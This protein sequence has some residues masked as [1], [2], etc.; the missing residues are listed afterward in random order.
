VKSVFFKQNRKHSPLLVVVVDQEKGH[1]AQ[2]RC[3]CDDDDANLMTDSCHMTFPANHWYLRTTDKLDR[4]GL[5][6][7]HITK[8]FED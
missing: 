3:G 8:L 7:D 2:H 1:L 5:R 6:T 4:P